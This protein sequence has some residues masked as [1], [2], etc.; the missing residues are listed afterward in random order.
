LV[1]LP[2]D[3]KTDGD[4]GG[5]IAMCIPRPIPIPMCM[6]VELTDPDGVDDSAD[7]DDM[8]PAAS[9]SAC[10]MSR[11]APDVPGDVG[12][13]KPMRCASDEPMPP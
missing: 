6:G 13:D 4:C 1:P 12:L 3:R 11:C 8:S 5:G 10:G 9:S 2:P 7:V